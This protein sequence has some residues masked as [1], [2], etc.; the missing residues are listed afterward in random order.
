M[1]Q[2]SAFGIPGTSLPLAFLLGFRY[3]CRRADFNPGFGR[4]IR[5]CNFELE[6]SKALSGLTLNRLLAGVG[7]GSP[8]LGEGRKEKDRVQNGPPHLLH[9][10]RSSPHLRKE[11]MKKRPPHFGFNWSA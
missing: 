10:L 1:P 7:H 6:A 5:S 11:A 2:G 4:K 9:H 8:T 3:G